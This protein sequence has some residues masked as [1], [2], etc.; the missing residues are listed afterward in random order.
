MVYIWYIFTVPVYIT[1]CHVYYKHIHT[2]M[3]IH[4]YVFYARICVLHGLQS[5]FLLFVSFLR[6][7]YKEIVIG[8]RHI[9][10]SYIIYT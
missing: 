9:Y 3:Y 8:G 1:R 2:G 4:L 5:V 7:H 6:F 10:E